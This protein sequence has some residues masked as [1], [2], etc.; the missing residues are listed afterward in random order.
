VHAKVPNRKEEKE[1]G[2]LGKNKRLKIYKEVN[3]GPSLS[4]VSRG[5][6]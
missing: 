4:G 5:K 2:D 6:E 3:T 1:G